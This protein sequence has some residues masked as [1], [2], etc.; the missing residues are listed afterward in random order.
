MS[1]SSA[2]DSLAKNAALAIK[3]IANAPFRSIFLITSRSSGE[4]PLSASS[5]EC[6]L[7]R[8]QAARGGGS[9]E[10]APCS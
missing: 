5:R 2:K 6:K 9:G 8:R 7:H 3:A 1:G 4:R 10:D